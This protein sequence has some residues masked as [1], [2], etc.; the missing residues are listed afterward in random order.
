MFFVS[1]SHGLCARGT[2]PMCITK[3]PISEKIRLQ[4]EIWRHESNT[5]WVFLLGHKLKPF[6]MFLMLFHFFHSFEKI[7]F[8]DYELND[9]LL[10]FVQFFEFVVF[11]QLR[12]PIL[13][14][15]LVKT[16]VIVCS[17]E[18][19]EKVGSEKTAKGD[20]TFCKKILQTFEVWNFSKNVSCWEG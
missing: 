1:F 18:R 8:K 12:R 6:L 11:C 3:T 10:I 5:R 20:M 19:G 7:I 16:P 2:Y 13:P 15:L 14:K 17:F 9:P 4:I